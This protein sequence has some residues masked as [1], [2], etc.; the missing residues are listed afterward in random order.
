[1]KIA[2]VALLIA[3]ACAG[4][5][6]Q[7]ARKNS[8]NY[9]YFSAEGVP[10]GQQAYFCNNAQWEGGDT[11]APY[12]LT[13]K[14][15]CSS[16]VICPPGGGSCN[17]QNDTSVTYSLTSSAPFTE[18]EACDLIRRFPCETTEPELLWD[19]GWTPVKR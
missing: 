10:V 15:G 6:V 7:A 17:I 11:S 5:D 16:E 12:R 19:F 9:V 4:A 1:M 8:I 18:E 13:I 14:G 2:S 3:L